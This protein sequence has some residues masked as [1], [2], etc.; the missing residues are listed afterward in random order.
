MSD[1][2]L[3]EAYRSYYHEQSFHKA[4]SLFEEMCLFPSVI[5]FLK[6]Q[7]SIHIADLATGTG[8]FAQ[9]ILHGL[10]SESF[11]SIS[12]TLQDRSQ[13]ALAVAE[14]EIKNLYPIPH[15]M[16]STYNGILPDSFPPLSGLQIL[17]WGN[18]LNEWDLTAGSTK[19][20][21][22]Y[23]D[24]ALGK[25]GI[26]L[27]AEPADR[28]SS[29]KLHQ[30][31]NDLLDTL[32]GFEILAPC[33]N[34]RR[35]K[36]PALFDESDWCHEDRPHRF[37]QELL[38]AAKRLGHIKDSLKMS[39]LICQKKDFPESGLPEKKITKSDEAWKMISDMIHERG[40]SKSTFCNGNEW[41]TYRLLKRYKFS[42]NDSF[43][44]LKK[45]QT[46]QIKL[47]GK[48]EKK[49]DAFNIPEGTAV[50]PFSPS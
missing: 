28:I 37:S 42:G 6:K 13:S 18:M 12:L 31:S 43:F 21:L 40:L 24:R 48:P 4:L 38:H 5:N 35:G 22:G 15:L 20:L 7:D 14:L 47:S 19:K 17:S 11:S 45:G 1:Q 16:T 50:L 9:G 23:I 46:V 39:Y 2:G 25:G 26:L 36:C 41:M 27:I 8:G 33:P 30:F 10:A 44:R 3:R 29:R 32:P 34:N 49:G